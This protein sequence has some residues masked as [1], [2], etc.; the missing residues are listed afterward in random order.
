MEKARTMQ[1]AAR[2][3]ELLVHALVNAALNEAVERAEEEAAAAAA[4]AEDEPVASDVEQE[5]AAQKAH[6]ERLRKAIESTKAAIAWSRSS[7]TWTESNTNGHFVPLTTPP[8]LHNA[9]VRTRAAIA[10][11]RRDIEPTQSRGRSHVASKQR[12]LCHRR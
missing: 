11:S 8:G 6:N 12:D 1:E 2:T 9:V 5:P 7:S 3:N 4:A 10:E